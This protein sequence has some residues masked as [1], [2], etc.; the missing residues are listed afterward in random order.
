MTEKT[1]MER[2]LLPYRKMERDLANKG[3]IINRHGYIFRLAVAPNGKARVVQNR[4][5]KRENTVLGPAIYVEEY[6]TA[7]EALDRFEKI[8]RQLG[9]EWRE[10]DRV[11]YARD[12]EE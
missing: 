7:D 8:K 1:R 12:F 4:F 10:D 11:M 5:D 6:D 9:N 3:V 2:L